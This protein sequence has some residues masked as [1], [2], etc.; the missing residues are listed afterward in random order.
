MLVANAAYRVYCTDYEEYYVGKT[1]HHSKKRF[2]EHW[3]IRKPIAVSIHMMRNNH[4]ISFSNTKI[5]TRR[6]N[7]LE[8]LIKETFIIK[9]LNPYLIQTSHRIPL[10]C[11]DQL[12]IFL[13]LLCEK[14]F[15]LEIGNYVFTIVI[16]MYEHRNV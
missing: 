15:N 13:R 16:M 5:L 11:F 3:D 8:L 4:D 1:K 10:R 7:D 9:Q 14:C 2:D 6:N 12:I